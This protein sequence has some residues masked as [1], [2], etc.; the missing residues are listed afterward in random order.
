MCPICEVSRGVCGKLG[1]V[2]Y[3][4]INGCPTR[5]CMPCV[6][7]GQTRPTQLAV[8]HDGTFD[9]MCPD[10]G[11]R[12]AV[13]R[14]AKSD[15]N[16]ARRYP[17]RDGIP[18]CR[19]HGCTARAANLQRAHPQLRDG[20]WLRDAYAQMSALQVAGVLGVSHS[21]VLHW[22]AHH[23]IERRSRSEANR[24]AAVAKSEL[25]RF[26]RNRQMVTGYGQDLPGGV[27]HFEG[28]HGTIR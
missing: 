28:V 5:P 10:C 22:L 3:P 13:R 7:R 25:E 1:S 20:H 24:L 18:S 2:A 27:K 8:N 23:G 9:V 14:G 26:G 4:V 11:A 6:R 16:L 17:L 15:D 19:C 21:S 12:R